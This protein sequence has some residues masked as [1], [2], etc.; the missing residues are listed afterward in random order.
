MTTRWAGYLN[1]EH[2]G[3]VDNSY[4]RGQKIMDLINKV[5]AEDKGE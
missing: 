3:P 1:S 4:E 5:S 2:H